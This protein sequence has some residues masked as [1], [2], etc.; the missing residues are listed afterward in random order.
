MRFF[1]TV[2]ILVPLLTAAVAH[3][4]TY[5]IATTS[6]PGS[7]LI[8]IALRPDGRGYA[9]WSNYANVDTYRYSRDAGLQKLPVA[10]AGIPERAVFAGSSLYWN[11]PDYGGAYYTYLNKVAGPDGVVRDLAGFA[12]SER[13][14]GVSQDE[15]LLAGYR[16][17]GAGQPIT[18]FQIV[19][20]VR[21]EYPGTYMRNGSDAGALLGSSG[22]DAAVVGADGVLRILPRP[23]GAAANVYYEAVA[24]SRDGSVVAGGNLLWRNGLAP[25]TIPNGNGYLGAFT[26]GQTTAMSPDGSVVVGRYG[27]VA[28][29]QTRYG[30][31]LWSQA[32]GTVDL[33]AYIG[34]KIG[35][36]AFVNTDIT[37]VTG[38]GFDALGRIAMVGSAAAPSN[39]YSY[40]YG[41][42]FGSPQAV[43]E[44]ASLAA[45]SL[46]LVALA[47]RRARR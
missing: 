35:G 24:A 40:P 3:G 13:V 36:T 5:T 4:Q 44:P 17:N 39:N 21:R 2:S 22:L 46:G 8:P 34:T 23:A 37:D 41:W 31:W 15:R 38:V 14:V 30:G 12:S 7:G 9:G 26:P 33:T 1:R 25:F 18:P 20:G 16:Y 19:D 45:L 47:R 32:T 43:P 28:G 10:N 29:N 11:A 6:A 27:V 42:F